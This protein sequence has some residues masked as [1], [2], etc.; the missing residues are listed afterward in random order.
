MDRKLSAEMIKPVLNVNYNFLTAR[1]GSDDDYNYTLANDYKGGFEF[2]FPLFIRKERAKLKQVKIKLQEN[3]FK[4]DQQSRTVL[5]KVIQA[6]NKVLTLQELIL[7]QQAMVINYETLLNGERIRFDNGES[8]VFLVNSRENKK[9]DAQMKLID[10]QAD[11]GRAIGLLEWASAR[12][13]EDL[14][15]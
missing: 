12:F 7:Q 15:Q 9:I 3:N 6:Y 1:N 8:S 5:N 14:V 13:S 11:Y 10:L 2:A 4:L